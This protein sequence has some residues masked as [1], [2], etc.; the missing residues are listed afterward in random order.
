MQ[1]LPRDAG[2]ACRMQRTREL[3]AELR[4]RSPVG[5]TASSRVPVGSTASSRVPV[6]STASSRVPVGSTASSRVPVGSTASSRVPVGSTASSRVP[7]GSTASSRVCQA[8]HANILRDHRTLS[9]DRF[10]T[11]QLHFTPTYN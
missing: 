11:R 8:L 5:S 2:T 6:G 4:P 9:N 1:F 10:S 3:L 7:V